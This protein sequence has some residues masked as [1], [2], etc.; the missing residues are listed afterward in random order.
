MLKAEDILVV[1]NGML[2]VDLDELEYCVIVGPGAR[3][4]AGYQDG[5][6]LVVNKQTGRE[7]FGDGRKPAKWDVREHYLPDFTA[8]AALGELV[9]QG[10][11]AG[12]YMLVGPQQWSRLTDDAA[13][14]IENSKP[15]LGWKL[16][17]VG[18]P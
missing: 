14:D 12:Y 4:W 16:V 18:P 5:E 13:E 15:N 8:A 11:S 1:L 17:Y 3:G 6:V 9:K 7:P 10:P 2:P